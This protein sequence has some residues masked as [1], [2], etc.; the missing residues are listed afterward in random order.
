MFYCYFLD[1]DT[2]KWMQPDGY[3]LIHQQNQEVNKEK[4]YRRWSCAPIREPLQMTGRQ[5][6]KHIK[7][8]KYHVTEHC[9]LWHGAIKLFGS[10]EILV[11]QNSLHPTLPK[12]TWEFQRAVDS[13]GCP[14]AY[15]K[16]GGDTCLHICMD[17]TSYHNHFNK[18]IFIFRTFFS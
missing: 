13:Q 10:L 9:V 2:G 14:S 18:Q 8:M 4:P 7:G 15:M 12:S 6:S 11:A 3:S 16:D 17:K 1:Q 5:H